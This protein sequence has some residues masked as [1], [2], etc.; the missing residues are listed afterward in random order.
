MRSTDRVRCTHLFELQMRKTEISFHPK[1]ERLGFMSKY[2]IMLK[3][4]GLQF[5]SLTLVL[6]NELITANILKNKI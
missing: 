5:W 1:R 2:S 4:K 3:L 6:R